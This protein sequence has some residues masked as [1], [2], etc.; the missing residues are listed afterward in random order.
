MFGFSETDIDL[1]NS[2][3]FNKTFINE[4]YKTLA[5][6]YHCDRKKDETEQFLQLTSDLGIL[7]TLCDLLSFATV[8]KT[9]M[10]EFAQLY[11]NY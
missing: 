5:K 3:V 8:L 7:H 11:K 10:E 4:R 2:T 6:K 9:A 1:N